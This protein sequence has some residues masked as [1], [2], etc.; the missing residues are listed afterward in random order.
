MGPER[1]ILCMASLKTRKAHQWLRFAQ[2]PPV[3]G[4]SRTFAV[5]ILAALDNNAEQKLWVSPKILAENPFL[6]DELNEI[7]TH[8]WIDHSADP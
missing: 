8:L 5:Q 7:L 6:T 1:G 3:L 4:L 2:L